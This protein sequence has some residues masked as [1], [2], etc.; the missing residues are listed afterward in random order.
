MAIT[1]TY[2]R[3]FGVMDE[4]DGAPHTTVIASF[5]WDVGIIT[6]NPSVPWN[7]DT[8]KLADYVDEPARA[9]AAAGLK[10]GAQGTGESLSIQ[11]SHNGTDWV[12]C[13]SLLSHNGIAWNATPNADMAVH[14]RILLLPYLRLQYNSGTGVGQTAAKFHLAIYAN[15]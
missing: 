7:G 1:T 12:T 14:A 9:V 15:L 8:I 2:K 10:S 11:M 4:R 5:F 13:P 6:A 3:Q